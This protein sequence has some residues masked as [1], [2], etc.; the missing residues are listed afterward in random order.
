MV[1]QVEK[2]SGFVTETSGFLTAPDSNNDTW[3]DNNAECMWIIEVSDSRS[4]HIQFLEMDIEEEMV[5]E[6]D[7]L[8]V[9][10]IYMYKTIGL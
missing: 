6:Y 5:C 7:Q 3:Y 10:N 2:C 8:K 4:I 1:G 9:R